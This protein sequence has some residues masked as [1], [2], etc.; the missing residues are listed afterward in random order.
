MEPI[1]KYLKRF[2]KIVIT[3]DSTERAF[4]EACELTLKLDIGFFSLSVRGSTLFLRA[5]PATKN[6][7]LLNQEKILSEFKMRSGLSFSVIK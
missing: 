4:R 2:Q 1:S 6:A 7:I 5:T 3:A